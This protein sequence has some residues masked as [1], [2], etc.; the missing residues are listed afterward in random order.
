[1]AINLKASIP[2]VLVGTSMISKYLAIFN[3]Y[4]VH[5]SWYLG[6]WLLHKW[7]ERGVVWRLLIDVF[8][9]LWSKWLFFFFWLVDCWK[10]GFRWLP[11]WST[12]P[13]FCVLV[14]CV[15]LRP[16][17][18][19]QLFVGPWCLI[20]VLLW[21]IYEPVAFFFNGNCNCKCLIFNDFILFLWGVEEVHH[22][23]IYCSSQNWIEI[24]SLVYLE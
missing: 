20:K 17:C 18:W 11:W 4:L 3:Q 13:I 22:L 7:R 10:V 8:P 9:F 2:T 12:I 19:C 23:L 6:P 24:T 16:L 5:I 14:K 21:I 1:M 15:E